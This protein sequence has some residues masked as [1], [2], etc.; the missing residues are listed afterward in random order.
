MTEP[1]PTLTEDLDR[2]VFASIPEA[3]EDIKAGKIVLVVDD[4]DRENEGDFVIAAEHCTDEAVNFMVTHGRGIVCLP[5]A[6]HRLDQLAIPQ[7]VNNANGDE[8]AFTISID[9]R[10]A[11]TTGTSAQDRAATARAVADP[12]SLPGDFQK[13]GHVFPLRA[14]EGG[15]LR[16]AGHTEASVDLAAMAGCFPA[17]VICEVMNEDGT[18]ARLPELVRV[19]TEHGLKII[20]IADLIQYRRH[21]EVLVRKVAEADIP[22]FYGEFRSFAYESTLDDRTHIALVCGDIGDGQDVLTRV[23]SECLTGD[24]FASLRC[25]CGAQ[26]ERAMEIVAAEGRGV[27][28]YVRGHEG[29]AIG[30]SHKLRAYELQDQG[31]DTV[32]ANLDLGLPVDQ[33]DYGI[34]AQIL[35]DLG[36]RTM[37]LLTNNPSKRAGLEGYG[38]AIVDRIP[39]Q[40]EPTAHNIGYLRTKREKMGHLIDG[41]DTGVGER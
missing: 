13:P 21:R 26:L 20:S 10:P 33:R 1:I 2:G 29:R 32:E 31:R 5:V 27:V 40:T 17:G 4:A 39:L 22:T 23:H 9:Y 25:D 8:T 18:M 24:V 11:I 37:R 36:V 19:A 30:L 12:K 16:R 7:M 34:G 14:K 3:I 38:L 41:L 28:L 35:Y 6:G 15:V